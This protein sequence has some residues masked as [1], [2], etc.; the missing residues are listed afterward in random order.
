M[1]DELPKKPK[2]YHAYLYSICGFSPKGEM[3]GYTKVTNDKG[4]VEDALVFPLILSI[5]DIAE[6]LGD[7]EDGM[8]MTLDIMKKIAETDPT[9]GDNIIFMDQLPSEIW[10]ERE[11]LAKHPVK[12][13]LKRMF[14]WIAD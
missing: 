10:Q 12:T 7:D 1:T 14:G 5:P 2:T 9:F 8:F 6:Q 4:V 13:R 11:E 3:T